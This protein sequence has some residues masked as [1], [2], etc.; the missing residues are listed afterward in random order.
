MAT[1]LGKTRD[2]IK[3]SL[4]VDLNERKS[5]PTPFKDWLADKFP[6]LFTIW[7]STDV[8][9]TGCNLSRFYE[10]ELLREPKFYEFLKTIQGVAPLCCHDGIS[11]FASE[12][13]KE[14]FAKAERIR[15]YLVELTHRKF[16]VRPIIKIDRVEKIEPCASNQS[17][18]YV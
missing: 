17:E 13:D 14:A 18:K 11:M 12:D 10:S 6:I 7:R 4:L 16:G 2:E 5:Y 8:A 9:N 1:D 15:D 3:H